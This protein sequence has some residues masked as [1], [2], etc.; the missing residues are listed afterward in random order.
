MKTIFA[1][2][3]SAFLPLLLQAYQDN[4]AQRTWTATSYNAQSCANRSL[5]EVLHR[6]NDDIIGFS[7]IAKS[8]SCNFLLRIFQIMQ[9]WI[10]ETPKGGRGKGKGKSKPP[11]DPSKRQ[12]GNNDRLDRVEHAVH[13]LGRVVSQNDKLLRSLAGYILDTCLV[14]RD[15]VL[16]HLM[17]EHIAATSKPELLEGKVKACAVWV[18]HDDP[19]LFVVS[20][21]VTDELLKLAQCLVAA[22][23]QIGGTFRFD[24][25]PRSGAMREAEVAIRQI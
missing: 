12:K 21:H 1:C 22:L 3:A 16:E 9:S 23:V 15:T 2:A 6:I 25:P 17:R 18:S 13:C 19:D 24:G 10:H 14:P 7:P 11:Y 20:F 8:S 5:K 4:I